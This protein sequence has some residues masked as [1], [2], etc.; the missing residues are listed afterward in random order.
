MCIV[1]VPAVTLP[2]HWTSA[3]LPVGVQLIGRYA[4][5]A[6]LLRVSA[7]IEQAQ[8]WFDRRPTI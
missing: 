6:T 8:P 2:L 7:Q 4:D 1:R 5:E 3:G